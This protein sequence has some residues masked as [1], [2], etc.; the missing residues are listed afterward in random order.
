M[1]LGVGG[2][3]WEVI[4]LFSWSWSVV[5]FMVDKMFGTLRGGFHLCP[6]R[7]VADSLGW[8]RGIACDLRALRCHRR[9]RRALRGGRAARSSRGV[10]WLHLRHHA[11]RKGV[12]VLTLTTLLFLC[13][14]LC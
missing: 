11:G 1:W 14:Q 13:Y 5:G 4:V 2:V 7:E 12:C 8:L 3:D 9:R 10:T 6:L